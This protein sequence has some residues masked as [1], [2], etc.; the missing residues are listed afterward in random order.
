[1]YSGE[2][3]EGVE[4]PEDAEITQVRGMETASE[5]GL[6]ALS[7]VAYHFVPLHTLWLVI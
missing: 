3:M 5:D 6:R 2:A 1:M 4:V 7:C